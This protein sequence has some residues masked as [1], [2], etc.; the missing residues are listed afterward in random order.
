MVRQISP[1]PSLGKRG[2][3]AALPINLSQTQ[4]NPFMNTTNSS[5]HD[6]DPV[7]AQQ[8]GNSFGMLQRADFDY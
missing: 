3:K 1:D 5:L 7:F 8:A 6:H 4:A 2:E